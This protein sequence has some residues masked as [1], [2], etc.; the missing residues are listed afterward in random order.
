MK[1]SEFELIEK[2]RELFGKGKDRVE[3]PIGDDAA[4]LKCGEFYQMLTCDAIAEGSHYLKSW[5]E[6]VEGLYRKLGKKLININASD[7]ASMGGKPEFSLITACF[8]KESVEEEVKEFFRGVKEAAEEVGAAIVGGDTIKG[9]GELFDCFMVG[10]SCEGYM[11]R[12]SA[13]PGE[14]VGITGTVGD[15]RGGLEILL[16]G[17]EINDYLVNRFLCPTARVGEG[18]GAIKLGVKCAT[19]VSDGLVFNLHTVAQSSKVAIEVESEKIPL[20]KELVRV[21]GKERALHFALY[22]GE[23][24]ELIITFP[25]SLKDELRK[26]GFKVIGRVRE[27]EGVFVDGKPVSPKGFDHFKEE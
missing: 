17:M 14:L 8:T 22:G 5:K 7:V 9:K 12:S 19:D 3:L 1:L 24:Y 21:F 6:R 2:I 4:V 25:E 23:D 27:G 26:I 18:R 10:E 11:S 15:A 13:K 20:S 16:K